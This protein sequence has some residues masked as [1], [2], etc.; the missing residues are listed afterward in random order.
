[1][2]AAV[3]I[4][5]G[6]GTAYAASIPGIDVY[7]A[8]VVQGAGW[9]TTI[10]DGRPLVSA[11]WADKRAN[12][13]SIYA[14]ASFYQY[15]YT[16]DLGSPCRYAWMFVSKANGPNTTSKVSSYGLRGEL[17]GY[18]GTYGAYLNICADIPWQADPCASR[19][20]YGF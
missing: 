14:N 13:Y 4:A 17:S 6:S 3:L 9:G 1:M 7:Y 20:R 15:R 16:C 11:T 8:G 12:S 5:I 2:A 10:W 18:S 19:G